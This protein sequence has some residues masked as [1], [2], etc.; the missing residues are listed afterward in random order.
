M[1]PV[2]RSGA[3]C[4][5][6]QKKTFFQNHAWFIKPWHHSRQ[7]GHLN[8]YGAVFYCQYFIVKRLNYS[9]W[10]C[11]GDRNK[12]CRH[13]VI[14]RERE[15]AQHVFVKCYS[16]LLWTYYTNV[17]L[18]I[19]SLLSV[20]RGTNQCCRIES[21]VD[22]NNYLHF[23]LSYPWNYFIGLKSFGSHYAQYC[24]QV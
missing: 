10:P 21:W 7:R 22:G 5:T 19:C 15:G 2:H 1:G 3:C 24:I 13:E 9:H 8:A 17:S 20:A 12:E 23:S 6:W 16:V 11:S 4:L 14:G 18:S